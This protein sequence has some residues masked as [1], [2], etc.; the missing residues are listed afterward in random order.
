MCA[1][2]Q[3]SMYDRRIIE[4][5][6]NDKLSFRMIA[7]MLERSASSISREVKANR[8]QL[9]SKGKLAECSER[10]FCKVRGLCDVCAHDSRLCLHCKEYDC[11]VLCDTFLA[12]VACPTLSGGRFVCNGCKKRTWGCT[13]PL[14]FEY[15]ASVAEH[16]AKTRRSVCRQGV[17]CTEEAFESVM[18]VVRPAL[19]RGMSPYEIATSFSG[20]LGVSSSTLY[21]WIDAGYGGMANI[22][23]E[24]KVG[25]APRDKTKKRTTTHH[26]KERSYE[27]FCSLSAKEQEA[28]AEMDTVVG[29]KHD[30]KCILTLYTRPSHFQ[31]YYLLD[32]KTADA[33]VGAFDVLEDILGL[34]FFKE[35]FGL[36][37]TDNGVE[38]EHTK[39]LEASHTTPGEK[40]C[41]VF[42]CDPRQSQQ[43]PGCEKNHTELRQLLPKRSVHFDTLVGRDI[44]IV[45]SH[46]NSTPRKSLCGMS[47]I[48]MLKAAYG[49]RIKVLFDAYGIE[50]IAPGKLTL[51][52]KLLNDERASR[53]EE[54]L[55]F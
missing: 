50:G 14:R 11:R 6:L 42:Y 36:I 43:K 26:G 37:I 49:E 8:S 31:L 32:E 12:R 23:L 3:F 24:R 18:E 52:P 30:K 5:G 4:E 29:R 19:A 41:R 1:Y 55:E 33:V 34:G 22:E 15:S 45:C 21:R 48:G 16:T 53:G 7:K 27:A 46:V 9:K 47:P 17:D 54:P 40:R 25:F 20:Q 51:K 39:R 2:K 44:S 10:S 13:R 28:A 35:L 38:F